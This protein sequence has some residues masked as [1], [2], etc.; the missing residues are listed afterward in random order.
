MTGATQRKVMIVGLDCAPPA[1]VFDRLRRRLPTLD[2][3]RRR[4]AWGPLRSVAPP[5]TVPAWACMTSGRDPGELGLYG[6]RN[7][8]PGTHTL[9]V[10]DGRA[11][12]APRIWDLASAVGKS[13]CVLYVPLTSPARE[14][15]GVMLGGFLSETDYAWPPELGPALEARFGPHRPD[16]S[17]YRTHDAR[18][19]LD[20][21]YDTSRHRFEVAR[22]LYRERDP[23]L[24][25]MVEMGPDRLHH[26]L[27]RHLDPSDP[28]HDPADPL[29]RE[30]ADYYAFLD[31]EVG[32]LLR[33]ADEDTAVLVVSDHGARRMEGAVRINEWLRRRGWLVPD[34]DGGIDHAR[35]RAWSTGGYYARIFFNVAGRDPDGVVPEAALEAEIARLVEALAELPVPVAAHRPSALYRACRG[36][37]PDLLL[38]FGDLAYRAV[39]GFGGALTDA[40]LLTEEDDRGP[41]GCNHDWEG[42]FL[43][44]GLGRR[45]RLEGLSLHDVGPTALGLLGLEAPP[46]WLGRDLTRSG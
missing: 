41:D 42:V 13:V 16:V 17:E 40:P 11:V 44:R 8:V 35:T 23:D 22:A 32:A 28:G 36:S 19:L 29:V 45:G 34:A 1:L 33:L 18:R 26:A 21:L 31:A 3:L 20:G 15:N 9:R 46:D 6:F 39:G 25:M 7:R 37:P 2:G 24:F 4:G 14:V 38:F 27:W 43:A 5:I 30:A 10:A 12:E